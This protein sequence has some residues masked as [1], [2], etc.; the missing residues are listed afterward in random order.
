[1]TKA[2]ERIELLFNELV[3]A[4][5]KANTVAREI[6]RAFMRIDYRN[7][8]DGDHIGVGYGKETCNQ[9]ARYLKE[10]CNKR[11][12]WVIKA[13]WGEEDDESYELGLSI[14]REEILRY[15]DQ[16]LELKEMENTEDMFDYYNENEDI[17]D[18]NEDYDEDD[19]Y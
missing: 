10:K 6:I 9:A 1:M 19:D 12:A 8:N 13:L 2:E 3:P 17:D 4:S 18:N 15:L 11:I 14:L 7:W 16:H 5:G